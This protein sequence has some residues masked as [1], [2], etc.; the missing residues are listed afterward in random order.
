MHGCLPGIVLALTHTLSHTCHSP[1]PTAPHH[2]VPGAGC[3]AAGSPL[4]CHMIPG[5][6]HHHRLLRWGRHQAVSVK[7]GSHKIL[8]HQSV[9]GL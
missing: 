6:S 9:C 1:G 4:D 7:P 2:T 8:R 5:S 3:T